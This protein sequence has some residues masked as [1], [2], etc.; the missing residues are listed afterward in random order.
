MNRAPAG[1]G[2]RRAHSILAAA[3]LTILSLGAAPA[4]AQT[5]NFGSGGGD[6][7]VE[8][9]ADNGIEWQQ[10]KLLFVARGNAK[11]VRG[12]VT[13]FGDELRAH[14]REKEG[15]GSEIQRLDA[16]G[17]VRIVSP[18]QKGFGEKAV[19]DV[20]NAILVLSGGRVRFQTEEDEITADRQ[21]EYWETKQMAVAR[22]N[23][24]AV[25]ED[26]RL[27]AE[28]IVAYFRKDEDN[29]NKIFRVDAFENVRIVTET[30]TATGDKGV[31]NVESGIAT[32]TGSVK[33]A[34]DGNTLDGCRAEV[35]LNTSV[36]K[37]FSCSQQRVRGVLH[38]NKGPAKSKNRP[39]GKTEQ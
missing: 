34:R 24:L 14:Y 4:E 21:L 8:I 35:N 11:A 32:L 2:N 28:I 22:G 27:R 25:R 37:L 6:Q 1:G 10:E 39:K 5:L 12:D 30:E 13:V 29:K 38:P 33:I 9:F 3:A 17:K 18:T 19:Y 23:A 20:E 36:S 26:K 15:G 16:I 31:Y 7:P